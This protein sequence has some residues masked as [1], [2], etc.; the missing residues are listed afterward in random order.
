[1]GNPARSLELALAGWEEFSDLEHTPAGVKLMAK[2]ASSYSALDRRP[3]AL[4]WLE[5]LIPIA[6]RLDLLEDLVHA[7]MRRGVALSDRPREGHLMVRGAHAMAMAHGFKDVERNG[8]ITM[9]FREQWAEPAI[10]LELGREG[11]EIARRL[12]S[13]AYGFMMVGN[14]VVCAIRVGEWDWAAALLEEWIPDEAAMGAAAAQFAEFFVDR[15]ILSA[16]RGG[17]PAADIERAAQLRSGMTDPQY[18]SYEAWARAWSAFGKGL[19][20]DAHEEAMRAAQTS[21]FIPL[22]VPL[23]ARASLW[24]G[25]ISGAREAMEILAGTMWRGEALALDRSSIEAGLAALEGRTADALALYRDTL[26]SWS[27][28]KLAWDEALTVIDMI[29]FLGAGEPEVHSAAEGARQTLTRLGARPYLD[30]L[31]AALAG[32]STRPSVK[33]A[34]AARERTEAAAG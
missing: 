26:R 33:P 19:F 14:S 25:N 9:T 12:G 29:A 23:A 8:R 34:P 18:E 24:D 3:D 31:E 32:S 16:L 1:M 11:F 10:G 17:N 28:L 27:A 4:V 22:A 30:R 7:F 2:I 5:R 13:R 15:A 21:F 6:E 20:G